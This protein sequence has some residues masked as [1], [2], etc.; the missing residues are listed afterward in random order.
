[1]NNK[2][3]NLYEKGIT[4][5]ALVVTII[6]MLILVGVTISV[7]L[8]GGLF[9]KAEEAGSKTKISQIQ[10]ALTLKKQKKWQT[11]M[12]KNQQIMK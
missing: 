9:G 2:R 1:M 3:C 5:I 6:V 7:A 11:I 12:E 10:E 4:V 8:N